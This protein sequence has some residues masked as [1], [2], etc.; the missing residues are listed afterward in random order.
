MSDDGQEPKTDPQAGTQQEPPN[1][2]QQQ[3]AKT[4]DA[5]YVK[6]LRD[7]AAS[8]RVKLKEFEAA[9]AAKHEEELAEQKKWQELADERA[10]KLAELKP[11][12][13]AYDAMLENLK[14][15]NEKRIES[16]PEDRRSLVPE[17]DDPSKVA[18]WLDANA[19]LLTGT[20][21][22]PN[23]NGGAGNQRPGGALSPLSDAEI[24]IAKKMGLTPEQYQ[25]EKAKK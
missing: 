20:P 9:Q 5:V 18:A 10:A 23:L 16:I 8:Y 1:T 2:D 4:F 19:A 6:Q 12:K 15:S 3:E 24:A 21:T 7:E 14:A 25:K 17:Y 22:A 13:T 11:I